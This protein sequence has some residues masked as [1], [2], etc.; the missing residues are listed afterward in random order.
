MKNFIFITFC[1]FYSILLAQKQKTD[2]LFIKYDNSLLIRKYDSIEKNF[3][4][5][6]KGTGVR[7]ELVYLLEEKV[8][9][10]LRKKTFNVLKMF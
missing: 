8:F 10:N 9:Y 6:I 4:Y 3:F 1:F 5:I 7:E 2:T